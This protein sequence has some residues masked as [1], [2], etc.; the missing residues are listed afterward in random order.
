M[1]SSITVSE[2]VMTAALE[3]CLSV[4]HL[5]YGNTLAGNALDG[6]RTVNISNRHIY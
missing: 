2:V 3:T 5:Q 1:D 4:T 6:L